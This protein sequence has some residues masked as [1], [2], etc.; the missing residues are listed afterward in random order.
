MRGGCVTVH[1]HGL[2]QAVDRD[3]RVDSADP[4]LVLV[5]KLSSPACGVPT[6]GA[7]RLAM[8]ARDGDAELRAGRTAAWSGPVR[9]GGPPVQ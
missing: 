5:F 1:V 8:R 6:C 7:P 2:A 9:P 3:D 4:G